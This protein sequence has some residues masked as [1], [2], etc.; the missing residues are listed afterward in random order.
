MEEN[1]KIELN[2]GTVNQLNLGSVL[3]DINNSVTTL[4]EAGQTLFANALKTFT[5]H[6]A[7]VEDV[8]AETKREMIENLALVGAQ[9]ALPSAE[10]KVGLIKGDLGYIGSAVATIKP[11]LEVWN[12]FAPQAE[13]F[14]KLLHL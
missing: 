12:I 14:F 5:E 8:P 7:A 9:A 2:N 10:R 4:E 13:S 1:V 6:V 11:L 3:G